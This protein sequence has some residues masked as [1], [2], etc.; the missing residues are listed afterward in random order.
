METDPHS[1]LLLSFSFCLS[2]RLLR[3]RPCLVNDDPAEEITFDACNFL[4]CN[5][6]RGLVSVFFIEI[7]EIRV[8][9][10]FG[11]EW[12]SGCVARLASFCT[13]ADKILLVFLVEDL[14]DGVARWG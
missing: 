14:A 6:R 7:V 3:P 1:P 8:T 12:V 9:I 13:L 4:S 11:I 2:L 5:V 10:G